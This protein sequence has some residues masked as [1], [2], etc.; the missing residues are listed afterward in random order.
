[1]PSNDF[2]RADRMANSILRNIRVTRGDHSV[3]VRS[4]GF[5]TLAEWGSM[6]TGVTKAQAKDAGIAYPSH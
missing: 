6:M 4:E 1:M 5:G 2:E 3:N